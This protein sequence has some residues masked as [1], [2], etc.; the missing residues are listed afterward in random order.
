[1]DIIAILGMDELSE[2]DK[3]V[4]TRARRARNFL[5]Q[6]FNVAEQFSGI[7]GR[8][9]PLKETVRS[10]KALLSGAYDSYPEQA[11]MFVG[12]IEDVEEKAR[13]LGYEV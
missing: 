5:S 7:P 4:V 3:L 1:Q 10:F 11:F 9:V 6:P 2:E 13:E 12:A 8:Y